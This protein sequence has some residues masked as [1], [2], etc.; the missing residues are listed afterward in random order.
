M[1]ESDLRNRHPDLIHADAEIIVRSEW[2]PLIDEYFEHVK[3][4]Y[5]ETKPSICLHTAYEEGGLVIDC[6]DT[7]WSGNQSRELKRRVREL[8]LDIHRRSRDVL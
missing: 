6:D 7:P 2:L 8:A 1:R 4:I 5:G 3:E